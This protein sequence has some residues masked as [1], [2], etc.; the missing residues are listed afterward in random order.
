MN[1]NYFYVMV[2][3]RYLIGTALHARMTN[4]NNYTRRDY[5]HFQGS[6]EQ[7]EYIALSH[8]LIFAR[9]CSINRSMG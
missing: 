4:K 6:I 2:D 5:K 9:R 1:S 7:P 3:G 8:I